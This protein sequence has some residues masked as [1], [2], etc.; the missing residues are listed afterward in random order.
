MLA[1][2][3]GLGLSFIVYKLLSSQ[4]SVS[5]MNRDPFANLLDQKAASYDKKLKC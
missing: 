2:A 4:A 3:V 1:S 5:Q